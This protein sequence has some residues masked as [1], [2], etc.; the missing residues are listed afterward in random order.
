ML[1]NEADSMVRESRIQSS[2]LPER[3][4][5][6][7][8][9]IVDETPERE[10]ESTNSSFIKGAD[11]TTRR[12]AGETL[13]VPVR[14]HVGDLDAI[15]TLN[16]IGSRIWQLLDEPATVRQIAAIISAEYE[17]TQAEAERD[18]AELLDSMAAA[19]LVRSMAESES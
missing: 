6:A 9:T 12:I 1:I 2:L 11:L 13:I 14:G 3:N 4:K 18:V 8:Q 17:V 7:N 5:P 19:G 10:M 16:E 15:Y